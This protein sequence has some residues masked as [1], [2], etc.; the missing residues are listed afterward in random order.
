MLLRNVL[1][2]CIIKF[3]FDLSLERGI[4]QDDL[5]IARVT[6]VFK[7]GIR[8]KL[9]IF[10]PISVPP[11]FSKIPERIMYNWFRKYVLE[12]KIIYTKQIGFQG[13]HLTDYA[14]IQLV[15]QT[16]VAFENNMYKL[17]VY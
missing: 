4:C 13:G 6:S 7:S 5:K 11:C 14:I 1:V 10:R 12:N 2:N 3:M 17:G 15:D 8:S 16:F 9:G